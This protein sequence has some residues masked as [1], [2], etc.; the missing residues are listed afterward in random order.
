MSFWKGLE[1]WLLGLEPEWL[2]AAAFGL[3]TLEGMGIPGVPGALPMAAQVPLIESGRNTLAAAV[4]W[5]T[6]GNWLGSLLG[7]GL[8]R[9]GE[10][11]LPARW[12]QSLHDPRHLA[13]LERWG[14]LLVVVS[15]T[16]GSLR[17]PVTLGAGMTRYPLGKYVVYSLIGSLIHIGVWQYLLWK[18]GPAILRGFGRY[19]AELAALAG[20][21]VLAALAWHFW[22]RRSRG[23][24]LDEGAPGPAVPGPGEA[25][26]SPESGK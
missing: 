10:G 17:T 8:G 7:Y 4:A 3:L 21:A 19:G 24:G 14:G 9:W 11:F 15:R 13:L 5:G 1:T 16:I 22:R 6:L 20:V 2:N 26:P 18:F 23:R 25:L 12:R